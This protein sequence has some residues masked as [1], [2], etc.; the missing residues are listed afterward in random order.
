MTLL[1]QYLVL[2]DLL[3]YSKAR[4]NLSHAATTRLNTNRSAQQFSQ[5]SRHFS[6]DKMKR[7]HIPKGQDCVQLYQLLNV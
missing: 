1:S 4:Y 5:D 7:T 6:S 2:G 3:Q